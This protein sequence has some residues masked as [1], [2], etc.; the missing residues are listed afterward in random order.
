VIWGIESPSGYASL[1]P[2]D[3]AE[4]VGSQN[5]G[6]VLDGS[7]LRSREAG[8]GCKKDP[9]HFTDPC[10]NAVRCNALFARAYGALNVRFLLSPGELLSCPGWR[11]LDV[12]PSGAYTAR[13]YEN[14]SFMPRAYVAFGARDV[15]DP[16]SAALAMTKPDFD[17]QR[18]VLRAGAPEP[19]PPSRRD[20]LTQPCA[21]RSPGPGSATVTCTLD[22]PGYLVIAE[23]RYPGREVKVDGKPAPTFA[24][25]G[26]QIGVELDAGTHE[27]RLDY[28]PRYRWLVPVSVLGWAAVLLAGLLASRRALRG[29]S[30]S[31]PRTSG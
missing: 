5:V 4:V 28:R 30:A 22:R 2:L 25:N 26:T 27:V 3:V 1:V 24:A 14:V 16:R 17:P 23:T 15:A 11:L 31:A 6:G 12:I 29:A 18:E 8:P 9:P 7:L 10:P 19:A 20:R 21:Y 13:L